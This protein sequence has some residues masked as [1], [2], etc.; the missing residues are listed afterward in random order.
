MLK[1]L[2]TRLNRFGVDFPFLIAPMVGL[3]HVAF[4]ELIRSYTPLEFTPLVFTEMLSSRRLPSERLH[5]AENLFVAEN[6]QGL[7]PQLLGNEERFI[8]PSIEKL[9]DLNP[10][11]IDINMGCPKKKNLSHNWGVLL[12]GDK[13]YA[14]G[15]VKITKKHS[16]VPVS[17]KLRAGLGETTDFSFLDDFTKELEDNGVDWMTIHCRARGQ[18]HHGKA[19]WEIVKKLA[20]KRKVPIVA[21]GDIQTAQDAIQLVIEGG[22]DGAMIARAATARPW[23]LWQIAEDLGFQGAA[24]GRGLKRAPRGPQE[25]G[26]E[27]FV[28]LSRFAFLIKKFFGETPESLQRL[29]FYIG[30]SAP[31]LTFGHHFWKTLYSVPDFSCAEKKIQDYASQYQCEMTERVS[32]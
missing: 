2:P 21:N 26:Q 20:Q 31:W 8:A 28:A 25:E 22:V 1:A 23:I 17:A 24:R 27:Y 18:K 7:I 14:G 15:V 3:S 10:W 30:V 29:K 13:K 9:Q 16:R 19:D 12:L 6:E 5:L 32:H 4:R 11:G